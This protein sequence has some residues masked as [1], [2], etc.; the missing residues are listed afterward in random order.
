MNINHEAII[1]F[2]YLSLLDKI[3][4]QTYIIKLLMKTTLTPEIINEIIPD[5]S[6]VYTMRFDILQNSYKVCHFMFNDISHGFITK[7]GK[8]LYKIEGNKVKYFNPDIKVE[9]EN[10]D[11]IVNW[12]NKKIG[13]HKYLNLGSVFYLS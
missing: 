2:R 13:N 3:V 4:I 12:F 11:K 10:R 6:V 7:D 9:D 1:N 5:N 8:M